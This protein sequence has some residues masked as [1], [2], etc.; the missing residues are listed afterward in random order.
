MRSSR[1]A[2]AAIAVLAGIAGLALAGCSSSAGGGQP[3]APVTSGVPATSSAPSSSAP[4][5]GHPTSCSVITQDEASAALGQQAKPPVMGKA[6]VEG[7]VACVFYGPD[8]PSGVSPDVPV[9]DSVRVVLVTGSNAKKWFDDYRSKVSAQSIAGLG[10][11]AFYDGYASISVLKG[12]AYV[13]IAV[14]IANNLAAEK[15]LAMDALP[16]M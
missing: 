3:P 4:A 11:E 1:N 7:G 5:A 8:V 14:G 16:R 10:D 9:A 13:R 12:D 2:R 15:Q 6:V